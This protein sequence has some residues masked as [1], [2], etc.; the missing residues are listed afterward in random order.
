MNIFNPSVLNISKLNVDVFK[1]ALQNNFIVLVVVVLFFNFFHPI[2]VW[3]ED[4][5]KYGNTYNIQEQDVLEYIQVKLQEMDMEKWQKDFEHNVKKSVNRPR[6]TIL[7]Y[8]QENKVYYYDPSIT[9]QRDYAN[10]KGV[11]FARKG[12]KIN[13]LDKVALSG[14]LLF[15]DGDSERQLEFAVNYHNNNNGKTKIILTN[16]AIIDLM[17]KLSIRL[18]FDQKGLLV[19][20]FQ[21]KN[22]PA[23]VSQENKILKIEEVVL[24][25]D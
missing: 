9:L 21:I 2:F 17:N 13:P 15:V 3:A 24:N 23:I 19:S 5:G 12:T 20:K 8:A 16:G 11:V 4:Y 10:E 14:N 6:P 18:Y 7:P 25:Y 22:I 1:N